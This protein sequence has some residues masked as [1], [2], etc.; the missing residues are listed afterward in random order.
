MEQRILK[1]GDLEFTA[2]ACGWTDHGAAPLVL[3]LHGFPDSAQTF[4]W[5]LPAL[6]EAGYRALAPTMRGYEPSSQPADGDYRIATMAREDFHILPHAEVGEY[7][8]RKALDPERWLAG[9]R[10][11]RARIKH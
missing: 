10:R 6:A 5:Q 3:C 8:K 2:L 11:F 1:S 7:M 4:R 9:M